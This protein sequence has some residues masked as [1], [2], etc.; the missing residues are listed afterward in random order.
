MSRP[1]FMDTI[2]PVGDPYVLGRWHKDRISCQG[3]VRE[4]RARLKAMLRPAPAETKF[5]VIGRARSGTTLL[6]RLLNQ[7]PAIRC[8]GETLHYAVLNPRRFLNDLAAGAGAPAYG[9]KLLSYQLLEVHPR[10]TPARFLDELTE[11]GFKLLHISRS[12]FHQSISL[13]VAQTTRQYTRSGGQAVAPTRVTLDVEAFIHQLRWNEALLAYE[14]T[15]LA[16]R[17]H[18]KVD[19]DSDLH[20]PDRQQATIDRL[21]EALGVAQAPVSAPTKRIIAEGYDETIANFA[22]I[23]RAARAEGVRTAAGLA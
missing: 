1:D 9:C 20:S 7:V 5:L 11:D 15:L 19:Y 6:V 17:P 3:Y 10:L 18:I 4:A 21:C 2:G 8:D 22:A 23:E 14:R 12:S 13:S 16:N